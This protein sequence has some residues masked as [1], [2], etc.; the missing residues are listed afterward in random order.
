MRLYRLMCRINPAA[1]TH[2]PQHPWYWARK[3]LGYY[4]HK[5]MFVAPE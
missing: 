5:T 4:A 1:R 2:R 3:P